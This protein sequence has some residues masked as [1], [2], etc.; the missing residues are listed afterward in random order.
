MGPFESVTQCA[1]AAALALGDPQK[2]LLVLHP[3][4]DFRVSC[5]GHKE[6]EHRAGETLYDLQQLVSLAT[7]GFAF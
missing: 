5:V 3:D 6:I 4:K 1:A 7:G 2:G